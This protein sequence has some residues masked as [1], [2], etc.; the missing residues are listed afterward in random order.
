MSE[1]KKIHQ[2]TMSG[3]YER[4][5]QTWDEQRPR[6]LVEKDW[7]D[8]FV[9]RLPA[10]GAVLDVGCGA[11][12]PIAQYFIERG[13]A[14]T[15]IDASL[16]MI[17]FCKS[18][19]PEHQW[20]VMDMRQLDLGRK[21]DGIIAWDSFF[22]LNPAEQRQMLHYFLDHLRSGG[23]LMMTVGHEAGEVLG[24][25]AGEQVYHSSL[26]AEEYQRILRDGG[27]EQ[28]EI[29]FQDASCG[30]RTVL[31]ASAHQHDN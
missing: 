6:T 2:Q 24:V 15:G 20:Q 1:F 31:L 12:E 29:V 22:H 10:G 13:F 17:N 16:G 19:F 21:V 30:G 18:R 28:I 4:N 8:K 14:V 26:S 3:V 25:V 5:A 27:L 23:V 7:L 11:G 9:S